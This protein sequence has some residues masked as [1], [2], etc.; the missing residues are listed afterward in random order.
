M[1]HS[2][3]K[4]AR[5]HD[6][7][8]PISAAWSDSETH[9]QHTPEAVDQQGDFVQIGKTSYRVLRNSPGFAKAARYEALGS[10]DWEEDAT[11]AETN[12][13]RILAF[14]DIEPEHEIERLLRESESH[15]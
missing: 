13:R 5:T 11:S 4:G 9:D 7:K 6:A 15:E 8:A 3:E 1:E 10:R 2:K 12:R 14:Q